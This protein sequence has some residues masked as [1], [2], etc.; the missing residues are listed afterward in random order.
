[1]TYEK[2]KRIIDPKTT[3][4]AYAET[5]YYGGFSGSQRWADDFNEACETAA[6]AL[7]KQIPKPLDGGKACPNCHTILLYAKG[8][9]KGNYCRWCGQALEW[10]T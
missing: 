6:A 4:E 7:D 1:M 8:E 9:V 3:L 10:E 5:E 2:A